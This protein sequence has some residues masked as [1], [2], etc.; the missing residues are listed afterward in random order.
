MPNSQTF[1]VF[2]NRLK[3]TIDNGTFS[4]LTLAKTIG[5]PEL[6][7]VYARPVVIDNKIGLSITFKYQ[8]EEIVTDYNLDEAIFVLTSHIDNPFLSAILF[9]NDA[10]VFMKLNK[11]KVATISENPPTFKNAHVV[12][13]EFYNKNH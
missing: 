1:T 8:T 6:K 5:N 11:K 2:F 4:K 7:N 13:S 3:E 12:I 9:C 10:D